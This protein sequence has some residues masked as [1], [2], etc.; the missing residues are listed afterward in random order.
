MLEE[1]E[2]VGLC[3]YER[4]PMITWKQKTAKS[5][6]QKCFIINSSD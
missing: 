2:P 3:S 1:K 5:V 4:K 6:L